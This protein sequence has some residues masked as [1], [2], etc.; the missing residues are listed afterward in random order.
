M[1]QESILQYLRPSLSYHLPLRSLFCLFLSGRLRQVLLYVCM[2]FHSAVGVLCKVMHD[3][4]LSEFFKQRQIALGHSLP[5]GAYLLKP[6]QRVLK[7]HL[8]LQVFI[9]KFLMIKQWVLSQEKTILVHGDYK[10]EDHPAHLLILS[11]FDFQVDLKPLC[12]N[13]LGSLRCN[14]TD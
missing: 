8:L 5:L 12:Y 7:Y 9:Q 4:Y 14:K 6:V 10:G 13:E 11:I 2:Y 1:L 3:P